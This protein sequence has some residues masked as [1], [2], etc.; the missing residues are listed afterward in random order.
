MVMTRKLKYDD[1][2]LRMGGVDIALSGEIK[3]LG[4][5]IDQKLTFNAHVASVCKRA[6]AFYHQLAR[7]A[8]VSWGLHPEVVRIIYIAVVEP[9]VLYAASV[10]APAVDKIGIRKQLNVVQRGFAQKLCRAYRTVSLNSALLLAGILPLNL[11]VREAATLYEAR[12]GVPQREIGDREVERM[13]SA[14]CSPHPAGHIDLE[15][16]CLMNQEQLVANNDHDFNIYTDGSKI[17]GKVGAALS[18]WSGAVETKTLKLAL[19]A[20]CTVYQAELLAICRAARMAAINL[21]G[22]VGIYSDSLSALQTLQNP[23]ALHPLAVEARGFLR[24]ALIQNKRI[25][26]FWIKAHAGL[27]GNERADH[28]AKEAALKS[29]R[30]F[31]YDGCPVSF[32]KR[33]IRKRSLEEWNGRYRAGETAGVTRI[34]FPDAVVAYRIIGKMDVDRIIT[35]VLT[36]HGGFSEYLHRFE[37]KESPGCVCDETVDE[38]ILHLLID[39]PQH[40]RIREDL[41]QQIQMELCRGSIPAI[42]GNTKSRQI[43]L[44]FCSRVVR[45]V[46]ERNRA[47]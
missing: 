14:F 15:F 41:L 35:Q 4:L 25:S 8:K 5:I 13:S 36:G 40:S 28:L 24:D 34:F 27:E 10:W 31:D 3:L 37:L 26:L 17:E 39:C 6:V 18:I 22:S 1:P 45:I 30:K 32:V 44:S 46:N 33:S 7:A 42:L 20:Y 19:P 23:K 9:V 2:R 38:S 29:K 21:A 16:K 43:F 47:K 11:R 12:K